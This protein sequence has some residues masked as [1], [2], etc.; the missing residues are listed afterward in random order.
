MAKRLRVSISSIYLTLNEVPEF[1]SEWNRIISQMTIDVEIAVT[2][3]ATG[4][5]VETTRAPLC[6]DNKRPLH[7]FPDG[8][9]AHDPTCKLPPVMYVIKEVKL[10][11]DMAAI[12]KFLSIWGSPKHNTPQQF[13]LQVSGS[14]DGDSDAIKQAFAQRLQE[15][16]AD[17]AGGLLPSPL[18]AV[19][20][21][22]TDTNAI[23]SPEALPAILDDSSGGDLTPNDPE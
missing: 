20:P 1:A 12:N 5:I 16:K 8:T 9:I 4:R 2:E 3:L 19:D 18:A 23:P 6:D 14:G 22:L 7:Y 13:A 21:P 10:P 11:P 15:L 17:P